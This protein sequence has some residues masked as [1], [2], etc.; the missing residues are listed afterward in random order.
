MQTSFEIG[1]KIAQAR[2]LKNLS[3]TDLAG[4]MSVTPQAVGKWERGESMPDIITFGKLASVLSVDLN[5]FGEGFP[6]ARAT[7]VEPASVET[8]KADEDGKSGWDMSSG[9]WKEADLFRFNGTWQTIQLL[10]YPGLQI[11][12]LRPVSP[13][14]KQ[15]QPEEQRF[16]RLQ[17][18]WKP[19]QRQPYRKL[20][21]CLLCF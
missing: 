7:V 4:Q 16:F 10:Q 1:A 9:V 15:Q 19:Y 11:H 17:L 20:P 3:Q 12:Q 2:K 8:V 5:Y 14:T 18:Q 13:Y 6:S 21:V